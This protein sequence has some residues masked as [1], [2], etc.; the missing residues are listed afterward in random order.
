[1]SR[2]QAPDRLTGAES[3]KLAAYVERVGERSALAELALCDATL[4][5]AIARFPIQR[6]TAALLRMHLSRQEQPERMAT[7]PGGFEGGHS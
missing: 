4:A 2:S 5:R 6:P 3:K 7:T 1:M